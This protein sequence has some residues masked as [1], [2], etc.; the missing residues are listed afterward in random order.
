M[1]TDCLLQGDHGPRGGR[2]E[3]GDQVSELY[4]SLLSNASRWGMVQGNF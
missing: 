1:Y 4:I 3:E 2:G